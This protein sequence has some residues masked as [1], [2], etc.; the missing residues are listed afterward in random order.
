MALRQDRY[1]QVADRIGGKWYPYSAGIYQGSFV[2][3]FPT[4]K[5][6]YTICV[7]IRTKP[8]SGSY[9]GGTLA[10][11]VFRMISDKIFASG[12]GAWSGPLDSIAQQGSKAM[13]AD[14]PRWPPI[15][16]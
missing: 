1:G 13:S 14:R 16:N 9:Y 3:Y 5:P 6:K 4:D 15:N 8:H 2:G 12:M 11:P 7:V 10:A